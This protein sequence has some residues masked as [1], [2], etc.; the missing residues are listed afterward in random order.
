MLLTF[1]QFLLCVVAQK[2]L[3]AFFVLR[4]LCIHIHQ[5]R[6]SQLSTWIYKIYPLILHAE[7]LC[8]LVSYFFE[9][10]FWSAPKWPRTGT[11]RGHLCS[12]C[13][14]PTMVRPRSDTVYNKKILV[15]GNDWKC[16]CA[17][18]LQERTEAWNYAQVLSSSY[19]SSTLLTCFCDMQWNLSFGTPLYK[20]WHL[21]SGDK[22]WSWKN[23]HIMFVTSIK[24]TSL[25]RKKGHF[26]LVLK[27]GFNLHSGDTLW[28]KKWLT[29]KII[30]L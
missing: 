5:E 12:N 18:N 8:F 19:Y 30:D 25:F 10:Q 7:K 24:R 23:V 1:L 2:M 4:S 27:P 28:L 29:T 14:N 22:I 17:I 15:L 6:G 13:G 26:S 20:G 9:T 3:K 16:V 11:W 21:H